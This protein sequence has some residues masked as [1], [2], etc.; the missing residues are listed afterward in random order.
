MIRGT[1]YWTFDQS[2][3]AWYFG[4]SERGPPPYK[5]QVFVEAL[6]DLDAD[7]RLAGIEIIDHVDGAPVAPPLNVRS[8]DD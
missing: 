8:D 4:L 1:A 7:G 3:G 6:L 2:V 5:R